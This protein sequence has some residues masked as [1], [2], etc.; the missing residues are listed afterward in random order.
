MM[1]GMI[2][3]F[4]TFENLSKIS[5]ALVLHYKVLFDYGVGEGRRFEHLQ[6]CVHRLAVVTFL[7]AFPSMQHLLL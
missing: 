3:R 5:V 4:Q 6:K 1:L 7:F 2:M